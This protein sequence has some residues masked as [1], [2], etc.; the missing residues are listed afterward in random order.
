MANQWQHRA[1]IFATILRAATVAM[2]IGVVLVLTAGI[3]ESA[4]PPN[5]SVV[6]NFTGGADGANPWAGLTIDAAGNIYGTTLNGG[7]ASGPGYGVVFQLKPSR[8]GFTFNSIYSFTGGADGAGPVARVVLGSNGSLYGT[9]HA[10]GRLDCGVPGFQYTG[11]GVVFQLS[12][13]LNKTPWTESVLYTFT[14]ASDGA[15][16]WGKVTFDQ[17]GNL[18]GTAEFGGNPTCVLTSSGCGTVFKLAPSG[19]SWTQSVLYSFTNG[20]DGSRP[21]A[22]L[23]FDTSGNLYGTNFY[24]AG[25]GCTGVFQSPGCGTVFK[26]TPAGLGWVESTVYAFQGGS[27]GGFSQTGV[28]VDQSGNLYTATTSFGSGNTGTVVELSPSSGS[29]TF[30][31]LASFSGAIF[32]QG[33]PRENLV[34]DLAG[35]L[36]GT[37]NSAGKYGYGAVF[38]LTRS[39]S[40]WTYTSLHDFTGSS[41]GFNPVSNIVFDASG[42]LYGTTTYGGTKGK[43]VVWKIKP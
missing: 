39:G 41:Y 36:Y 26:L 21:Y 37:T 16:P 12:P 22:G 23:T 14:G 32:Q 7:S 43:G 18:Y 15:N 9:A 40:T 13:Q 29:W 5:Y 6:Y 17:S 10:G 3:A 4:G 30:N 2:A 20:S 34:M 31:L 19:G 1:W 27:D 42:N 25:T 11:C 8:S 33:G 35:N 28:I 24:G 38:K